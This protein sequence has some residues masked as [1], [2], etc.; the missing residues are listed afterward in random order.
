ME[1]RALT[2]KEDDAASALRE[3]NGLPTD[4]VA[5][6]TIQLLGAFD[7]GA[8]LGMRTPRPPAVPRR[9][10]T[11]RKRGVGRVLGERISELALEHRLEGLWLLTTSATSY[12]ERLAFVVADRDTT[13]SGIKATAQYSTLC[14]STAV[15]M[16]RLRMG[17]P[18]E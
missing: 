14:P 7:N 11:R 6:A 3:A 18:E 17:Q 9:R 16:R 15:V 1:L 12:F 4:D 13:P 2:R 5:D 10:S 8:L